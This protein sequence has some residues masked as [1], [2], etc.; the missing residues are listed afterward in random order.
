ML[1]SICDG[2]LDASSG[3]TD[4][5]IL[6]SVAASYYQDAKTEAEKRVA[7]QKETELEK[8]FQNRFS[9]SYDKRIGWAEATIY[10]FETYLKAINT[11]HSEQLSKLELG[12]FNQFVS[13]FH[14]SDQNEKCAF[15]QAT[16]NADCADLRAIFRSWL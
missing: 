9:E 1:A 15:I 14:C 11:V 16:L 10:Y 4:D 13:K 6:R 8:H 12:L 3:I 7:E 2:R 5:G